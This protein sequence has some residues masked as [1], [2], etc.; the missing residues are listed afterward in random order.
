[1]PID[2]YAS[3]AQDTSVMTGGGQVGMRVIYQRSKNRVGEQIRGFLQEGKIFDQLAVALNRGFRFPQVVNVVWQDCGTVNAAWDGQGTIVMC[4]ELTAYL[5]ELF[6]KRLK[7]QGEVRAAVMSGVVFSFLHELGHGLISM[8]ELPAVG[9][10]ED[11]ADQLAALILI[12]AGDSGIAVA[13]LG[14]EF[15]R[16]LALSGQKT[17]FF[18]EHSL[19]SQRFYNV[20]C[21]VYGSN[22][23]RLTDLVRDDRLPE[24]R[25]RRCPNEYQKI[26]TAWD[27]LLA[28]HMR[29]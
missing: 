4:Y 28:D 17:P 25:A 20:L 11:A 21:L 13:M 12:K 16:Q 6:A 2:P 10:E 18:D 7:N 8:F 19:D 26:A 27:D 15:F 24:A 23:Q 14:A 29:F 3:S 22:P 9:R 5:T 1:M